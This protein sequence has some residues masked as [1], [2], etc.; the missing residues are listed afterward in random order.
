[1]KQVG[2]GTG[3]GSLFLGGFSCSP[4]NISQ[5]VNRKSSWYKLTNIL[6]SPSDLS[7]SL[8]PTVM[9]KY[10]ETASVWAIRVCLMVIVFPFA[11]RL[12]GQVISADKKDVRLICLM[13][14]EKGER[15]GQ[16]WDR[17]LAGPS[18][19]VLFSTGK[20]WHWEKMS[21]WHMLW[22]LPLYSHHQWLY[23]Q[24]S[25]RVCTTC[26]RILR[27]FCSHHQS[28][29]SSCPQISEFWPLGDLMV[30]WPVLLWS[31]KLS[32]CQCIQCIQ[33]WVCKL[34]LGWTELACC[35]RVAR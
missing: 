31:S 28:F 13:E 8:L 32:D 34:K 35:V 11:Y 16:S 22:I 3:T 12:W 7:L 20:S 1:M 2:I 27:I 29:F 21:P 6:P 18:V 5:P 33:T 26:S 4:S 24:V 10:K 14:R 19:C 23:K 30:Q 15:R 17:H 25:A 9:D